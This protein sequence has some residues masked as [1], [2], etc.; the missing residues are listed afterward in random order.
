MLRELIR[1]FRCTDIFSLSFGVPGR[2]PR[3]VP[4][5]G[6]TFHGHFLPAGVSQTNSSI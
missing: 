2:L 6:A 3:V 1:L 4:E 5:P